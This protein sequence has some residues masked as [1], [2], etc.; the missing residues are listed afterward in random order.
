MDAYDYWRN[1]AEANE[2]RVNAACEAVGAAGYY[3]GPYCPLSP[4]E[5]LATLR[6]V[7]TDLRVALGLTADPVLDSTPDVPP[8]EGRDN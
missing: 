3:L 7:I 8:S 2:A 1:V 6:E 5:R 4:T